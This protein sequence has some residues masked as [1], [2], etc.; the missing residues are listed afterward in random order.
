MEKRALGHLA[1]L[2]TVLNWGTT[3]I[4]TKILLRAFAPVEILVFR[5]LLGVAALF[6]ACPHLLRVRDR[7]QELTF[8]AAGLTAGGADFF[9]FLLRYWFRLFRFWLVL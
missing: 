6:V 9:H 5:F 3:F 7:R 1:A 2:F 8:A 4:A